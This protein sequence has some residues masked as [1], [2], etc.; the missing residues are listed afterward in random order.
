M[1]KLLTIFISFLV[2]SNL[3]G[4]N[5]HS[6]IEILKIMSKS[7]VQYHL[8]SHIKKIDC[9]DNSDKLNISEYYRSYTGTKFEV[10]KYKIN[11][12]AESFFNDAEKSFAEGNL[13]DALELYKK[14]YAAD[15]T[16]YKVLTYIGQIYELKKDNNKAIEYYKLVL[17]KNYIDYMAHWFLG[18]AYAL[19][20]DLI[21][22]A[23]EL[24]MAMILNRNNPRIKI[25]FKGFCKMDKRISEDWCFNPQISLK[26]IEDNKIELG[27]S[28][29]WLSYAMPKALWK[30]EP[31][32][33][34]SMGYKEGQISTLEEK[35]CLSS[36]VEGMK[37]SRTNSENDSI[38]FNLDDTQLVMLEKA[39]KNDFVNEFILYEIILPEKPIVA[40]YLN[41]EILA[42]IKDYVLQ[43]RHPQK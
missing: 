33:K 14:T 26:K 5:I 12:K 1:K 38:K 30:Y 27:F 13:D 31:G 6:Q 32:Y 24:T 35:E 22:A 8:N 42:N 23:D 18:D 11:K 19:N 37:N 16:Y 2:V 20:G 29:I 9:Q 34:E 3:F 41:D 21:K 43:I 15:T 17:S 39:F 40:Y 4:Q 25:S 36:L 10:K 7:N 28:E